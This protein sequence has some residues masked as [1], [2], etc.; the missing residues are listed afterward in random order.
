MAVKLKTKTT[1]VK[2]ICHLLCVKKTN[3]TRLTQDCQCQI[4]LNCQS[5]TLTLPHIYATE[6]Y[7]LAP[8][9]HFISFL[10]V[11]H[12]SHSQKNPKHCF[13]ERDEICFCFKMKS[14]WELPKSKE[15]V[16]RAAYSDQAV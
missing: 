14:T 5:Y 8:D 7:L 1:S 10:V 3:C 2:Y 4:L 6:I 16:A 9:I 15:Q 12:F 13:K 11:Q